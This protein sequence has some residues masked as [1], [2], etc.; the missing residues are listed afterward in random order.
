MKSES[1][2]TIKDIARFAGVTPQTVSRA[3]SDAPD[4]SAVTR[5]RILEIAKTLNYVKNTAACTFRG[6]KTK[7]IAI[8]YDNFTNLYFSVMMDYLQREFLRKGYGIIPLTTQN[9]TLDESAYKKTVS[10][11]T[12]G[13]I[14]F[15][16]PE[17][18][19]S[20]LVAQYKVPVTVIGRRTEIANVDCIYTDDEGGGRLAAERLC[21]CGCENIVFLTETLTLACAADRYNGLCKR[22]EEL[23]K[24]PPRI[25][26]HNQKPLI[27]QMQELADSEEGMPDAVFCFNDMIAFELLDLIENNKIPPVKVIGYDAVQN[28][29]KLPKR[30][31]SVASNKQKIAEQAVKLMLDKAESGKTVSTIIKVKVYLSEGTTA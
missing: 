11:G 29:I 4:V 21:E 15:L 22:L 6:A 31:T 9:A 17:E 2:V 8:F 18:S 5:K 23:N 19:I 30:I 1:R 25:L 7:M 16:Q 26:F 13:I 28:E 12:D 27:E 24:R 14:S 3:L 10:L 20:R